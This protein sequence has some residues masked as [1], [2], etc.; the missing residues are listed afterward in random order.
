MPRVH[1]RA[2]GQ[3]G[4]DQRQAAVLQLPDIAMLV[5]AMMFG[6]TEEQIGQRLH[7]TLADDHPLAL[8]GIPAETRE[9]RQHRGL[10][11]LQLQQQGLVV[12]R[13]EQPDRA[14]CADA[15][16]AHHFERNIHQFVTIEQNSPLFRQR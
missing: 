5:I 8:I 6:P 9:I 7:D 11:F 3:V 13:G 14:K 15:A 16:D 10:G 12:L 1:K 2:F 4:A